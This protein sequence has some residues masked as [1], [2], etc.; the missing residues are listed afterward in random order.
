MFINEASYHI[1]MSFRG[2]SEFYSQTNRAE[3]EILAIKFLRSTQGNSFTIVKSSEL[4]NLYNFWPDFWDII[5]FNCICMHILWHNTK[6]SLSNRLIGKTTFKNFNL[7]FL[8]TTFSKNFA[9]SLVLL[10]S[11]NNE[12]QLLQKSILLVLKIPFQILSW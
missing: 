2:L 3:S 7:N 5:F 6:F 12:K 1:I 8:R 10:N 9:V 4:P 11:D